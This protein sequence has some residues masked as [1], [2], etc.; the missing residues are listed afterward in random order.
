MPVKLL[1]KVKQMENFFTL[2]VKVFSGELKLPK[3]HERRQE[4]GVPYLH[5]FLLPIRLAL[6]LPL[7]LTLVLRM[8]GVVL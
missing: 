6:N 8:Q 3:D 5:Y 2:T 4:Y 1:S 7:T